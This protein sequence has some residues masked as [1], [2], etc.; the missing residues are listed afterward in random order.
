M[1]QSTNEVVKLLRVK[2]K[3]CIPNSKLVRYPPFFYYC[4][5]PTHTFVVVGT[6]HNSIE[7]NQCPK[8]ELWYQLETG[9]ERFCTR[10]AQTVH[11]SKLVK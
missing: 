4:T 11:Y 2:I 8:K 1:R 5:L 10:S 3:R 6:G 7:A 9:W